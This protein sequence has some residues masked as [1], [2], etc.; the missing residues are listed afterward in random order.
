MNRRFTTTAMLLLLLSAAALPVRAQ[1]GLSIAGGG[2]YFGVDL[3]VSEPL[4][5]NYRAHVKTGG[6]VAPYIGFMINDYI[7]LQ[8]GLDYSFQPPDD[9]NRSRLQGGLNNEENYT[10]LL[11][12]TVGPR[13]VQPIGDLFDLYL[14]GQ[15]GMYKGLRGRLNQWAPGFSVGGGLDVNVTPNMSVGLFGRY[16]MAFMSPH[17]YFLIGQVA[18]EQ[19]PADIRWVTAGLG[20]KWSFAQPPP[21]PPPPPAAA[22]A[23]PP[24]PPPP[25]REKIVLRGVNFDFDKS[26]IRADARVILDEAAN[27]LKEHRDVSVSVEGH[28]D[29]IGSDQYNMRLSKRRA[30]SVR[31]YLVDP[32]I[33]A[34]RLTTEGYGEQ[35]PVA[36]NDT[37]DGRA[38]NRRVELLVK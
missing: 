5:G 4:N 2:P 11:G 7:G 34:S 10:H 23:P 18:D 35:R 22:Q 31:R 1:M 9:D 37:A 33:A 13:I 29:A 12:M 17:P 28:T 16:H 8:A 3:G 19:G 26:N 27:I 30:E 32:G 14:V 20:L 6:S 25:K 38:Q 24:P 21:P 36:T 15:G